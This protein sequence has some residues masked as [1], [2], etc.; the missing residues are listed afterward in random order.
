[1]T[2]FVELKALVFKCR[3][4][5]RDAQKKFYLHHHAFGLRICLRFAK[6]R[7]CAI[8]ILNESCYLFFTDTKLFDEDSSI[9]NQLRKI[10]IKS[11]IDDYN[12]S[13]NDNSGEQCD[14]SIHNNSMELDPFS[15]N[16]TLLMLQRLPDLDRIIFNLYVFEDYSHEEIARELWINIEESVLRLKAAR[17][18]LKAFC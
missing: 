9:E 17:V 15:E 8:Q 10:I 18:R 4:G 6:S 11:V 3:K 13:K 14:S 1:M 16:D 2:D 5:S 7:E 12:Q